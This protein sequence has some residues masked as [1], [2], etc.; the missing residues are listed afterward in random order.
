MKPEITVVIPNYNG[1]AT[2]AHCLSS[3]VNSKNIRFEIVVV[4]DGSYD[5]SLS[6]IKQYPCRLIKQSHQGASAARNA[7]A[8]AARSDVLFFTD[9]DC[10]L[11]ED[12]LAIALSSLDKYGAQTVVGGS[13]EAR[14]FD[15]GFFSSF[16]SAFIHYSETK[17]LSAPDYI[18]T[19]AMVIDRKLFLKSGGFK[20]NWLPIL[21]DVEFSH[22][23][24]RM[25]YKAVINPQLLVKHIFN[26]SLGQSVRN[27][28][29][30]ASY[31]TFYSMKNKDLLNDSGTASRE[32]KLNVICFYL[33]SLFLLLAALVK[34]PAFVALALLAISVNVFYNR[35]LLLQFQHNIDLNFK[36]GAPLYYLFVYPVPV[37]V[38]GLI[39]ITRYLRG[40]YFKGMN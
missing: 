22:R 21:E 36:L 17:H 18:A 29:R 32:L 12:T 2:L 40:S 7:G 9:A 35:G 37:S 3:V 16:Q 14:P 34:S 38:G 25:G 19:H 6:V 5:D 30:K 20:E 24:K 8:R 11:A 31:W 28:I 10:V 33:T 4:D 1:Q 15:R 23:L 26:F 13:Y 27:A 39:G